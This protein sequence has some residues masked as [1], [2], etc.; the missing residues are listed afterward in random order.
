MGRIVHFL[1]QHGY[2]RSFIDLR[3]YYQKQ[4][5]YP[6]DRNSIIVTYCIGGFLLTATGLLLSILP[7]LITIPFVV[8]ILLF[9]V[10]ILFGYYVRELAWMIHGHR[11]KTLID[12]P[13]SCDRPAFND[14]IAML[15]DGIKFSVLF[16]GSLLLPLAIAYLVTGIMDLIISLP[17]VFY[18]ETSVMDSAISFSTAVSYGVI[19][20]GFTSFG[21]IVALPAFLARYAHN[22][23]LGETLAAP[24]VFIRETVLDSGYLI[25]LII[26]SIYI[27]GALIPIYIF[28]VLS[29][30]LIPVFGLPLMFLA[31]LQGLDHYA[32]GYYTAQE[33]SPDDKHVTLESNTYA[34][35]FRDGRVV[36]P[37]RD[38]SILTLGETGSGKTEAIKLLAH[39]FNRDDDS[40][41]IVFDY[42][43]DY[44]NFFGGDTT[45]IRGNGGMTATEVDTD[46]NGP[47]DTSINTQPNEDQTQEATS[48]MK[49]D[50][51]ETEDVIRISLNGSTA[52]WNI[53]NEVRDGSEFEELVRTIFAG[54]I[55]NTSNPYFPRAAQK[56]LISFLKAMYRDTD[57]YSNENLRETFEQQSHEDIYE[58]LQ[59]EGFAGA[60]AHVN[61]EATRQSAGVFGHLQSMVSEIFKEDFRRAGEFS[62]RDYMEDPEGKILVLDFPINRGSSVLP[63]YRLFIDWAIRHALADPEQDAYFILDEFQT[64][65]GLEQIERLVNA[66]RARNTYAI[67]GLQSKAQLDST[68][69]KAY[70]SSILSGLTQEIFLRSGDESSSEYIR[71]RTGRIQRDRLVPGPTPLLDQMITGREVR[72]N[73]ITTEEVYQ[74]SEDEIQSFKPGEAIVLQEDGWQRGEFYMLE[75]IKDEIDKLHARIDDRDSPTDSIETTDTEESDGKTDAEESDIREDQ[76]ALD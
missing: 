55:E 61:P 25:H 75:E 71:S 26:G 39:Q 62:I 49:G 70:A 51:L 47:T 1:R 32:L 42:K 15:V 27:S 66:G 68:Y 9:V 19:A 10:P 37:D 45:D 20:G 41:F 6:Q 73:Q 72:Y 63:I 2:L 69:G 34:L 30:L 16:I 59:A 52:I 54:E 44:K 18:Q 23:T 74:I 14:F 11:E 67:L 31:T 57:D 48:T 58:T 43:D 60:A 8:P 5:S 29:P 36:T 12:D 65:P 28:S 64:I 13:F 21:V 35:P 24:L 4:T 40:P 56:V 53:F 46:Q 7:F 76:E 38:R 22:G 50:V 33:L 17:A 3:I